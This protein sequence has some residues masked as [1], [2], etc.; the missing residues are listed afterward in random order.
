MRMILLLAIAFPVIFAG[1]RAM[2]AD[3]LARDAL[4]ALQTAHDSGKA[5]FVLQSELDPL[6]DKDGG[7][8]CPSAAVINAIQAVRLMVG[9]NAFGNPQ[10]VVLTSF[11]DQPDLLKGR[12][13]N[14]QVVNLLE[15]YDD[16]HLPECAFDVTV[17]S[18]SNSP[19][20]SDGKSWPDKGPDL[21]A[22]P[23]ELL[24][25]SYTVTESNGERVGR[26][27]V[28]FKETRRN[29]VLVVDPSSPLRDR[30]YVLEYKS[31][32]RGEADR[33]YLLNPVGTPTRTRVFELNTVFRISIENDND[34][35]ASIESIKREFDETAND[36]RDTK[37]FL[38]PIAWRKKTAEFGLPSLDL[39]AEYGGAGWPASKMIE[40]FRHAG[41]HNLNFRDVIGGAHVRP[42]LKSDN[43]A[44]LDIVRQVARGDGYIA[45]AITE[46]TAGS[47]IPSI[48]TTSKPVDGGYLL[49]GAKRYNA[50]LQQASHVI[51]FAQ[52]T[53]G[54]RGKLSV[55]VL[56]IKTKGMTVESLTAHGLTGNSYGGLTLKDVVVPEG[57]RIGEDGDGLRIFFEHFLYRRLMQTAAAIGTG[58]QALEQ[59]ANRIKS[60]EA[61]GGPIGRFTHLQQPIGQHWTELQM[62]FALAQRAAELIDRGDYT[63]ARPLICGLKAEGVEIAINAVDSAMRAFGGE[64]YS[65]R[66]DL[67]DR[68][69]DLNGLRIADGTT[70]VMRMEVVRKV[71]G[72]EFWDM[73]IENAE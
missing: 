51:I 2:G 19:Y 54:E 44:V 31:G 71:Y 36:L 27:F 62:A 11:A 67:G 64:G 57:Q 46:P 30:R 32:D 15:F 21:D 33:I 68:L 12:L 72:E 35:A 28:V 61:F 48:R 53:T 24:I 13:S 49:N 39:P 55:F 69:R 1:S 59:M 45:I 29:Q 50:R 38:S 26:H 25:L 8:A 14:D 16:K 7:G 73:A 22:K 34:D 40:I 60:R 70:D 66:V 52:G 47:D 17:L 3:V 20:A 63:G 43:P 4:A 9:L 56:P 6:I 5:A 18:A 41:R 23:N 58:E 65:T 10:K 42:L 37:S